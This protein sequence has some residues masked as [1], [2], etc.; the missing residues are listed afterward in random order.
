[1]ITAT[2]IGTHQFTS[3]PPTSYRLGINPSGL[4]LSNLKFLTLLNGIP[5][6]VC[7]P[8]GKTQ[9]DAFDMAFEADTAPTGKFFCLK[10]SSTLGT[11]KNAH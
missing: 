11:I 8:I 4:S 6:P 2:T 1:V 7:L 5:M 3:H 9:T 10:L